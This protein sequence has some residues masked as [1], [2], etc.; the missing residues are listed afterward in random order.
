MLLQ[1]NCANLRISKGDSGG[2]P[3][4]HQEWL[5]FPVTSDPQKSG[6]QADTLIMW[7]EV[8]QLNAFFGPLPYKHHKFRDNG[9][10]VGKIKGGE[11][12]QVEAQDSAVEYRRWVGPIIMNFGVWLS[13]GSHF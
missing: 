12:C 5:H 3:V 1:Q 6:F 9:I 11:N 10:W 4:Q 7:K 2:S 13:S 8:S